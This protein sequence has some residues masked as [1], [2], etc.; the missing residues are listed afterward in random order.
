MIGNPIDDDDD[1]DHDDDDDDD[2]WFE[3]RLFGGLKTDYFSPKT[4]S[5]T[6]KY[7]HMRC[8]IDN[9]D[10]SGFTTSGRDDL[11]RLIVP[12]VFSCSSRPPRLLGHRK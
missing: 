12:R 4:I 3:N 7:R 9:V 5:Q 8:S 11:S 2:G 1:D 6:Y 10:P